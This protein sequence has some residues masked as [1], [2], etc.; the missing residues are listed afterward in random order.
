MGALPTRRRRWVR[1]LASGTWITGVVWLYFRYFV[2]VTDRFGFEG[3]H[4]QQHWWL[5]AHAAASF[6]AVWM[7]GVLWPGHVLRCWRSH[8]RRWSGGTL[9]GV[10]LWLILTGFA[11]YYLGSDRL[12]DWTSILHWA[13]GLAAIGAWLVHRRAN[14][15]GAATAARAEH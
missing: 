7:Y 12:R 4:P 1:A 13:V 5:V 15:P 9:F 8:L 2:T 14:R 10:T 3:P 11:L 6:G